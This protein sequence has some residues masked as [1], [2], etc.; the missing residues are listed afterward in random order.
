MLRGKAIHRPSMSRLLKSLFRFFL[1]DLIKPARRNRVE[2]EP[3]GRETRRTLRFS[4]HLIDSAALHVECSFYS[5]A[6]YS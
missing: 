4:S 2:A 5:A 1:C 3:P 6:K